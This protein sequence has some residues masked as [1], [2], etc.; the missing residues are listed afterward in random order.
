MKNFPVVMHKKTPIVWNFHR[1]NLDRLPAIDI[2]K[3]SKISWLGT[4]LGLTLSDRERAIRDTPSGYSLHK[5]L[6]FDVKDSITHILAQYVGLQ[7]PSRNVFCLR[8]PGKEGMYCYIFATDLRLDLAS[9]TVVL[10]ACIMPS[11]PKFSTPQASKAILDINN[12]GGIT[13]IN[14][15]GA[16]TAAWTDLLL[17]FSERCRNYKHRKNCHYST[18]GIPLD[19]HSDTPLEGSWTASG[20]SIPRD[21]GNV[22]QC[23][24]ALGKASPEFLKVKAWAPLAKY[25]TRVAISPLFA[26]S[27]LDAVGVQFSKMMEMMEKGETFKDITAE[28]VWECYRCGKGGELMRC[29]RCKKVLYCSSECQKADWRGHKLECK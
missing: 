7:G 11:T 6:R 27:Y 12:R 13:L 14:T 16:E 17:V 15:C 4:H 20:A 18:K 1:V 9:H 2:S 3:P 5:D 23:A 8:D 19:Y 29:A 24:C 28:R 21:G 10:D 25:V 22:L 26:V